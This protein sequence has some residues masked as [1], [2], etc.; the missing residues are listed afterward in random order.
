[1][2]K[3]MNGLL[4]LKEGLLNNPLL[5]KELRIGLREKRVFIIQTIY[6]LI[7]GVVAFIILF[8]TFK[9]YHSYQSYDY[10][11]AG[12]NFFKVLCIVQWCLIILVS[13][14]LTS[15]AISSERERK[16]YDMLMVTLLDSTEIILGK[17]AYAGSYIF[18]LLASSLPLVALVFFMG[19]V[20]PIE[21][22]VNYMALFAWGLIMSAMAL[23]FSS[24]EQR[25]SVAT[26]HSY[27]MLIL[28]GI[29]VGIP[30]MAYFVKSGQFVGYS[31]KFPEI[32]AWIS[33]YI[34][35]IWIFLFLFYKTANYIRPRAKNILAIHRL[36][37]F[38]FLISVIGGVAGFFAVSGMSWKL[39]VFGK[40]D[41]VILASNW[42]FFTI[43]SVFLL[44][45]FTEQSSFVSKKEQAI[46][47]KSLTSNKYFF[48]LFFTFAGCLTAAPLFL[49]MQDWVI[50][51]HSLSGCFSL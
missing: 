37:I 47:R 45:C 17:I 8:S 29:I 5:I 19:G 13:P 49:F 2:S 46:F 39:G 21:V 34:N 1:M 4:K 41:N 9:D 42:I 12:R 44:G 30:Y 28:L 35:V 18:L 15:T 20:S 11:E 6:M 31:F 43:A 27:G 51:I 25:S 10:R 14:S 33:A 22:F 40:F 38:A 7:L 50:H 32:I 48:P 36:F 16:T 24:R 23:F 3:T 26:R